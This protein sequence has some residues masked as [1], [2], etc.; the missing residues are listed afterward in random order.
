M[1]KIVFTLIVAFSATQAV[2]S[3]PTLNKFSGTSIQPLIAGQLPA[4]KEETCQNMWKTDSKGKD[5][6][7]FVVGG[8]VGIRNYNK[9]G[10][11]KACTE[12]TLPNTK[13]M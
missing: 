2:Y 8:F 13:P 1:K 11:I 12:G 7:K 6:I 3:N 5:T 10:Y 9:T 4:K